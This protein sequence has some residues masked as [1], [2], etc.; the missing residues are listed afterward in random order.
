MAFFAKSQKVDLLSLV[1]EVGLDVSPNVGSLE[2]IKWIQST[3]DY[4]QETFKDI[5]KAMTSVRI[6]KVKEQKKREKR[7][8]EA[9]EKEKEREHEL[10]LKKMELETEER[11]ESTTEG[12][13]KS[14]FDVYRLILKFD[15]KV[16]DISLYL[17]LFERQLKRAK[18]SEELWVSNLF[19]TA[20]SS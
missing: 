14:S 20:W 17:T 9:K 8:F 19:P 4:E 15:P 10:L 6:Q 1:A 2:L 12:R 7:E 16:R 13:V 5:L 18:V 3:A 11:I